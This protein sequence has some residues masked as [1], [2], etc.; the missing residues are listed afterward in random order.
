MKKHISI[1]RKIIIAI[2]S[3]V[4]LILFIF[5]FG[6]YGWKLAG[7]SACENAGIEKVDVTDKKVVNIKQKFKINILPFFKV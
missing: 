3:I 6:R 2:V 4:A 5:M 7:F 1:S